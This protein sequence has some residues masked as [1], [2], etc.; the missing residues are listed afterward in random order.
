[1]NII[2]TYR[3]LVGAYYGV[4]SLDSYELKEYVLKDLKDYI[5]D[6]V[7]L[8]YIKTIDYQEEADMVKKNKSVK[9]KLQDS[10]LWLNKMDAPIELILLVKANIKKI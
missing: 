10:L 1:M 5:E 4:E 2:D 3:S 6:Y 8:N 7:K 9:Q